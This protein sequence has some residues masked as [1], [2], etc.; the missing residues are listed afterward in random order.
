MAKKTDLPPDQVARVR[1]TLQILVKYEPSE[2]ALARKLGLKPP[3]L[4]K[5]LHSGGGMSYDTAKK[6]ARLRHMPVAE[7]LSGAAR[8]VQP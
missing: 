1:A 8:A 6:A 3:S 7:L 5:I 4:H 2:A